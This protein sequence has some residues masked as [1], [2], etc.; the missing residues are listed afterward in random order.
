MKNLR[1]L[2]DLDRDLKNDRSKLWYDRDRDLDRS[3]ISTLI[4]NIMIY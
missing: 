1:S 3:A 2:I 4:T